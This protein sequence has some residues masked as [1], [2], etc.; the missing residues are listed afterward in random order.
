MSKVAK[1]KDARALKINQADCQKICCDIMRT[2]SDF[3][4][5][6]MTTAV[7][8]IAKIQYLSGCL[9]STISGTHEQWETNARYCVE[10]RERFAREGL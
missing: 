2:V 5:A 10:M 8:Q 6:D 3:D 9:L 1:L 7:Q 4:F